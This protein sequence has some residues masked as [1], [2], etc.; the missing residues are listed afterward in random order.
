M[1]ERRKYERFQLE[2]PVRL[3]MNSSQTTEMFELQTRNIS[4]AGAFLNTA[5]RFSVGTRCQL[6][7]I[8]ASERIKE[9][10]GVHGLIKVE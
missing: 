4:A 2:L 3:E 7:L 1:K 6:E 8:V 5:G 10:T 9:I